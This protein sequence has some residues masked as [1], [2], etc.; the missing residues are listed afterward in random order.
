MS[1]PDGDWRTGRRKAFVYRAQRRRV[2]SSCQAYAGPPSPTVLREGSGHGQQ[3]SPIHAHDERQDLRVPPRLL[4]NPHPDPLG[5]HFR[6]CAVST[7]TLIYGT[8]LQIPGGTSS[9][10]D[11]ESARARQKPEVKPAVALRLLPTGKQA[12]SLRPAAVLAKS[13]KPQ[14]RI[15]RRVSRRTVRRAT[16]SKR[17]DWSSVST[18]TVTIPRPAHWHRRTYKSRGSGDETGGLT[19]IALN[20]LVL[21]LSAVSALGSQ[22]A[23]RGPGRVCGTEISAAQK[24]AV[25]ADFAARR[26]GLAATAKKPKSVTIPTYFH[27]IRGALDDGNVP[28][29]QIAEQMRVLN[30]AFANTSYSFELV[31]TTRTVNINWFE[32]ASNYEDGIYDQTEMKTALRRGDARTLNL[33]SVGFREGT[34]NMFGLLGY[35]TFPFSY[36]EAPKDDGV[37]VLYSTLPGG[38]TEPYNLGANLV[39]EVGHWT[40]L[41]HVFNEGDLSGTCDGSTDLVEDTPAQRSPTNGCPEGKDTCPDLPGLDAIHNFMDYST[42][43]CLN[44]FTPGQIERMHAQMGVYRGI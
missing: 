40:G 43:D 25:E 38:T 17:R 22:M 5:L 44:D 12:R 27:V 26:T 32:F 9:S 11:R 34:A 35:G 36:E 30:A 24:D 41:Y 6:R 19:M 7:L 14:S 10:A 33:Y 8:V 2:L 13:V 20:V 4:Q 21:A 29:S 37:V 39:H 15:H 16:A 28:D 23:P 31:E 1:I 42:D 18:A 3:P